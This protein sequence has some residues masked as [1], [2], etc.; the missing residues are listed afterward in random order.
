M[1]SKKLRVAIVFC[2]I[3]LA[4]PV[5]MAI[6]ADTASATG[7]ALMWDLNG[8]ASCAPGTAENCNAT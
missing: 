7:Y 2:G 1:L 5:A 4:A 6:T 8:D 3:A